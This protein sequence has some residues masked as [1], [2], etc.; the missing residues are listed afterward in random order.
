MEL[1]DRGKCGVDE[2][3]SHLDA[4]QAPDAVPTVVL[5]DSFL[6]SVSGNPFPLSGMPVDIRLLPISISF[7]LP[8]ILFLSTKIFVGTAGRGGNIHC[9]V[10]EVFAGF[11]P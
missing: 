2:Y 7:E 10:F 11:P 1:L 6:P 5:P 4:A 9:A 3:V 8:L